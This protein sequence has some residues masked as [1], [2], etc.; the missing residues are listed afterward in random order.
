MRAAAS[1]LAGKI[2]S[3][4]RWVLQQAQQ[5]PPDFP[6]KGSSVQPKLQ[7]P[8]STPDLTAPWISA[9][10]AA[11]VP[12]PLNF[13]YPPAAAPGISSASAGKQAHTDQ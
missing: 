9:C 1:N 8:G 10:F 4:Q 6:K 7:G 3:T 2:S 11:G 5:E 13:C 12:P